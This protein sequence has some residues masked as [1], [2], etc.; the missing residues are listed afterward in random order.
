MFGLSFAHL[1]NFQTTPISVA[2]F[3][4]ISKLKKTLIRLDE[5]DRTRS[6]GTLSD[7]VG[8]SIIIYIYEFNLTTCGFETT[9][10]CDSVADHAIVY[11]PYQNRESL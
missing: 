4:R 2:F 7:H 11:R 3:I 10:G 5:S 6:A 1:L 8:V 9:S